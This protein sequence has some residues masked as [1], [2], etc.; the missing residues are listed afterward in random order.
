MQPRPIGVMEL[1]IFAVLASSLPPADDV[2]IDE[3]ENVPLDPS[4]VT[5]R[6][7]NPAANILHINLVEG[8]EVLTAWIALAAVEGR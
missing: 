6:D 5:A 4:L 7:F 2:Y 3:F 1:A 8:L